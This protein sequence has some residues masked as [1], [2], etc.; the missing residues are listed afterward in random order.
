MIRIIAGVYGYKKNGRIE[1]K[2]VKSAP[3]SVEAKE[4]AR[5]VKAGVAVYV[6]ETESTVTTTENDTKSAEN[7]E[8]MSYN[9]LRAK[10]SAMGISVEGNKKQDY[11]DAIMA[12]LNTEEAEEMEEAEAVSDEA[13]PTFDASS[14]VV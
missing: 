1:A 10:A 8:K 3:F 6:E 5:L 11:I 14:T 7:I 2:T 13:A 12:A 4:E 9:D